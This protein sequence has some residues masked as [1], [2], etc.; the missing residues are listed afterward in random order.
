MDRLFHQRFTI[1]AKSG[2]TVFV[3]LAFWF[4]WQKQALVGLFLMIIVV[5]MIERVLHTTYTFK[6]VKPIDR[7]E[8]TEFLIVDKGRFSRNVNIPVPEIKKVCILPTAFRLSHFI[9]IEYGEGNVASFQP[10]D[11]Q[12]FLAELQ[13]RKKK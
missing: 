9:L 13:K 7:D 4:F 1:A 2:I 10:E 8:E 5:G 12:A 3:L 6:R 11:D